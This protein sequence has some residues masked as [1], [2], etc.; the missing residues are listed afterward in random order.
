MSTIGKPESWDGKTKTTDKLTFT[1]HYADG[2]S[3]GIEEGVLFSINQ[4]QTMD[5][6]IGVDRAWKLF[7]CA[8]C[9]V[10]YIDSIGLGDLFK[11]YLQEDF[12]DGEE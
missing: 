2:T 5:I 3:A 7:G 9:L 4:D 8:R 1:V 12:G 11:K 6:H 10:K